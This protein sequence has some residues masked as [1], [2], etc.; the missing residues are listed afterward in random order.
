M[1]ADSPP[2]AADVCSPLPADFAES[3]RAQVYPEISG[4]PTIRGRCARRALVSAFGL[5][6]AYPQKGEFLFRPCRELFVNDDEDGKPVAFWI[7]D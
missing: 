7:P 3:W 2:A 4:I 5:P 1:P 6:N